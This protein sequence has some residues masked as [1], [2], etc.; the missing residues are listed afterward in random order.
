[1]TVQEKLKAT[2]MQRMMVSEKS[3]YLGGNE[4]N[5]TGLHN[6]PDLPSV[7]GLSTISEA[8]KPLPYISK[9]ISSQGT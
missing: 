2:R 9:P 6:I 8:G 3:E 1:M 7:C 5:H 4:P